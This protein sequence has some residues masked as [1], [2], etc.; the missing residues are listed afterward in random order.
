MPN[1]YKSNRIFSERHLHKND[2]LQK[3]GCLELAFVAQGAFRQYR[4]EDVDDFAYDFLFE[5]DYAVH[6]RSFLTG[7]QATLSISAT[8]SYIRLYFSR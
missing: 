5:E 1:G 3:Q 8:H 6:F 7:A 2:L 4:T